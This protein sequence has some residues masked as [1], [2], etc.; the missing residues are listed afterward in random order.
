MQSPESGPFFCACC[1]AGYEYLI[2]STI[3]VT[4]S[5]DFDLALFPFDSQNLPLQLQ[6]DYLPETRARAPTQ[7][8]PAA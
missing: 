2:K 1:V 4:C 5:Y 6:A 3:S 7:A 8:Q